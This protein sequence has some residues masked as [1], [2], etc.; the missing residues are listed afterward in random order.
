MCVVAA[1]APV[2][3]ISGSALLFPVHSIRRRANREI[4]ANRRAA[5]RDLLGNRPIPLLAPRDRNH[6]LIQRPPP[7][8]ALVG[9]R[10]AKTALL[11]ATAPP[12]ARDPRPAKAS[13]EFR[14]H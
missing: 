4:P 10:D 6:R 11:P 1:P 12:Q 3:G 7:R 2:V 14:R 5:P 9:R 8:L 13:A